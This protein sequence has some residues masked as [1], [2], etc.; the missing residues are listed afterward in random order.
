M[1][2]Y[3]RSQELAQPRTVMNPSLGRDSLDRLD[4]MRLQAVH[5]VVFRRVVPR[6]SEED[7]VKASFVLLFTSR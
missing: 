7:L 6:H 3:L 5:P 2:W 1:R 4:G